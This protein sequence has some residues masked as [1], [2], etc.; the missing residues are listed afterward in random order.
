MR[1]YWYT[2]EYQTFD[3]DMFDVLQCGTVWYSVLQRVTVG[4]NMFQCVARCW[5]IQLHL[6]PIAFGVSSNLNLQSQSC[7]SLFNG[8]WQK[9]PRIL[10]NLLKIDFITIR[11]DILVSP[12][13]P[14]KHTHLHSPSLSLAHTHDRTY[15]WVCVCACVCVRVCVC[16]CACVH[17]CMCA[18]VRVRA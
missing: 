3:L 15:V 1:N 13:T 14:H 8:T 5:Q 18:C 12:T 9:R 10:E 17:V 4:C 2:Y 16:V 6:Q 7:W 11:V